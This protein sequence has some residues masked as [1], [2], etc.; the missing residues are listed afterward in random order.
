MLYNVLL[1]IM[2][3]LV[4]CPFVPQL[5]S[6]PHR[7]PIPYNLHQNSNLAL[8]SLPGRDSLTACELQPWQPGRFKFKFQIRGSRGGSR[9]NRKSHSLSLALLH[10]AGHRVCQNLAVWFGR[11]KRL[12]SVTAKPSVLF[13]TCSPH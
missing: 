9:F 5:A 8:S 12:I 4:S 1:T 6:F 10:P 7:G 13:C 11:Y 3:T 2:V